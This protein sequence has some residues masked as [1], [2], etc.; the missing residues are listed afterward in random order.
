MKTGC[1]TVLLGCLM[2]TAFGQQDNAQKQAFIK[3]I[4]TKAALRPATATPFSTTPRNDIKI[5]AGMLL[6]P[7]SLSQVI[8]PDS[9]NPY[10]DVP[11]TNRPPGSSRPNAPCE[12]TSYRRLIGIHNGYLFIQSVTQAMDGGLFLSVLMHDTTLAPNPWWK[13]YGL[14]VKLDVSGDVTWIKQFE[15]LTPANYSFFNV[16]KVFELPNRDI[17]CAGFV[18]N[19][20]SS[21]IYRT[22]IFRLS[23]EGN[24]IWRNCLQSGLS[25]FNS[26]AGTFTFWVESAADGLNGDVIL[27]GTSNSNLSSGKIETVVRLDNLGKIVWDAN[28]GNHGVDGSYLFGSE[29]ISAFVQNGQIILV[30]LSHGTNYPETA[31]AVNFLTLNYNNGSVLARRFFRPG[32]NFEKWF[33]YWGNKFTR[34][35]N[36]HYLFHGKL[37]S[38]LVHTSAVKDHFGVIEFDASFNLVDAYTISSGLVTNY[39]NNVLHFDAAGK[40]LISLLEFLD[41]YRSNVFFGSFYQRQL[42]KQRKA[43]YDNV[44]LPGNNGFGFLTGNAYGYIQSYFE[45]QPGTKSYIEFRKMHDS[46]TSSACLGEDVQLLRFL[47]LEI[48]EDPT[49]YLLD[50]NDPNKMTGQI[51]AISQTDTISTNWH[52]PCQQTNFCDTIKIHGD[53]VICGTNSS[54]TFTAFRSAA[55]GSSVLWNINN[56]GIDSL[57]VLTDTSVTIWFKNINWR[58]TLYASLPGSKCNE[59]IQDSIA[60]SI[61]RSPAQLNLGRDTVLCDP[62][63]MI[64]HA[65]NS[66]AAYQWQDGTTDSVFTAGIPGIYWVK[67]NDVCGNEY[68]DSVIILP[69]NLSI[70]IGPDR[71]KCNGDTLQLVAPDGFMSYVWSNNYH[72]SDVSSKN[73][74]VDPLV[75][76]MYFLKAEKSPGCFAYDTVSIKVNRSPVVDLGP[77]IQFCSGDSAILNV[78][79]GFDHY[80]WNNGNASRQIS[81][82]SAGSYSVTA[83]AAN[84]CQSRD[85]VIV[86]VWASPIVTLNDNPVLCIGSS[87]IL[88]PGNY[89]SY[90]WQDGSSSS[91][92]TANG[93]GIYHVTVSNNNHCIGSDTVRITSMVPP[94]ANFLPADTSICRYGTLSLKPFGSYDQYSWNNNAFTPSISITSPGIYWLKVTDASKCIGRDSITIMPKDCLTGFYVPNAFT[95]DNNGL[96]DFFRPIITGNP[97]DYQFTIYNRWGQPVFTTKDVYKGWDGS[98]RGRP[99]PTNVF[100]W[101]CTYK[102]QGQTVR[103][104]KG[105]VIVI[106]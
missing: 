88:Q 23:P 30:G 66:F 82:F 13:S 12:D 7:G 22:M 98:F 38:D 95:P 86:N 91:S 45:D 68:T 73:V 8:K 28:Y 11:N 87:R 93:I 37:F 42:I 5:P 1:L 16:L 76:T 64:L 17:I 101:I 39:Y 54:I 15:D 40:G 3:E 85:T 71:T 43:F 58:G 14:L 96:N 106:K 4:F 41:N 74:V 29:G 34:L 18:N 53:P 19:D 78:A 79:T 100:T 10:A 63:K 83:T 33:T 69:F 20:A 35:D 62:H 104:E 26:P 103:K 55:C 99:Q 60:V 24:I 2:M 21:N 56:E 97:E 94:P 57:Q 89:A 49:Y 36:G 81:I 32:T 65:G 46:D 80:E 47:P 27:C 50:P 25:I 75:D 90:L 61:V 44:G 84:G 105:K 9:L 70:D 59:L 67:V 31:P 92:Y 52:N 48:V 72:I 6:K 51:V 102:L 77:D